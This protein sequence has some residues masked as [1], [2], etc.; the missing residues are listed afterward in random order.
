MQLSV[1]ELNRRQHACEQSFLHQGITFTVYG[2]NQA[3][4]RISPTD[5]LPRI[6]TAAEWN[7]ID[8]GLKQRI[9]ALNHFLR[10]IYGEA[11]VLKDGLVPRGLI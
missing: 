8:A 2:N 9:Q 5:V 1:E 3:T 6:I 10:D 11:R 7:R 4:E